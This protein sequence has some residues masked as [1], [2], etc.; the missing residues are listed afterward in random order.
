MKRIFSVPTIGLI[1][2]FLFAAKISSAQSLFTVEVVGKGKPMILIHGLY[3][4]GEVWEETVAHYKDKYECHVLTLAGFAGNAPALRENFL[5]GVKDEIIAYAKTKKLNK[6]ILMGHSMGGF[7]SMWAALSAPGLFEKIIVVDANAYLAALQMPGA[8]KES[9]MPMAV[10][11]RDMTSKQTPEQTAQAQSMFL[12]TMITSPERIDQ[13][14]AMAVK[15]D[16]KTQG[17]VL[18]ELY[19]T[20]LRKELATID[21]PV[22]ILGAYIAYKNYGVTKEM[23]MKSHTDQA[24]LIKNVKIELNDIAK[25]FIFYDDEKWFFE[26]VDAFVK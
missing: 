15:S 14:K 10:Q 1:L 5:S 18:Y 13:V 22:L 26:K 16:N 8:T 25:H 19:T 17:Q 7:L 9:S 21:C 24:A 11:M 4:S 2:A 6:P 3:C 12:P 20:D 23:V